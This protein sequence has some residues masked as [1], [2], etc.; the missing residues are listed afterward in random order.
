MI[1]EDM[2]DNAYINEDDVEDRGDDA[3]SRRMERHLQV[4]HVR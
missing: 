2:D 4:L 1:D 3:P